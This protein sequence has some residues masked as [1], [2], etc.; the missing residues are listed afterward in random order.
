MV[1][2]CPGA[3]RAAYGPAQGHACPHTA[4]DLYAHLDPYAG[5]GHSEDASLA[6]HAGPDGD[7]HPD[8]DTGDRIHADATPD[9]ST[10]ALEDA[11]HT[12]KAGCGVRGPYVPRRVGASS[13]SVHPCGRD[14]MPAG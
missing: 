3:V 5:P 1:C 13:R 11:K 10:A 4:P 8:T 2:V 12:V 7:A 9:R 6:P 14:D